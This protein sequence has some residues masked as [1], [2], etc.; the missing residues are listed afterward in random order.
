MHRNEESE[1]KITKNYR[2]QEKIGGKKI[3]EKGKMQN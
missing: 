1:K 2:S 3:Q